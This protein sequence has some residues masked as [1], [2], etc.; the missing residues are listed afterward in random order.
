MKKCWLACLCGILTIGC[1]SG[2]MC[3]YGGNDIFA[4]VNTD[5]A[6]RLT[7]ADDEEGEFTG[8]LTVP[9]NP[10]DVPVPPPAPKTGRFGFRAGFL[11]PMG[12]DEG[13]WGSAVSAGVFLRSIKGAD[14]NKAL[15][16][17]VDFASTET[18]D[19]AV[20]STLISLRGDLLFGRWDPGAG[21][22]STYFLGG[23]DIYSENA[24]VGGGSSESATA[25]GV[26]LGVG[27]GAASGGWDMRAVYTLYP[28]SG[29]VG[30][31][32]MVAFGLA[33]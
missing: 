8:I 33:F 3:R 17:G 19:G 2:T 24:D 30:G 26:N 12:A 11:M 1:S 25:L 10:P 27:L 9:V 13:E 28:G 7:A 29:N 6:T 20:S 31:G 21:G 4:A 23:I 5:F 14:R 15:E 16:F 32:F 18:D 22:T